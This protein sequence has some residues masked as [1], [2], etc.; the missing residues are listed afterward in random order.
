MLSHLE[1]AA[2]RKMAARRGSNVNRILAAL[3]RAELKTWQ[4][5]EA[6]PEISS[7]HDFYQ[8]RLIPQKDTSLNRDRLRDAE[9]HIRHA[10]HPKNGRDT[11]T[12]LS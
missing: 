10:N 3:A 7:V 6:R 9:A 1:T 12:T 11:P 8:A 5:I 2:F 4:D